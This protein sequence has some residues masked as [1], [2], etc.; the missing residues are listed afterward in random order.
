MKFGDTLKKIR[1]SR[2]ITQSSLTYGQLSHTSIS[3][4]E[5]NLTTPSYNNALYLI[6]QLG[7]T[8]GEFEYIRNNCQQSPK[9]ALIQ[10][11]TQ[12]SLLS[13]RTQLQ[14]FIGDCQTYL[15]RNFDQDIARL[16][17][18][19]TAL[20]EV[21]K[22]QYASARRLVEPVWYYLSELNL[23]TR[24]DL[25]LVNDILYFFDSKMA[26]Q[27]MLQ[28]LKVLQSKYP[29]LGELKLALV[30]NTSTITLAAQDFK[31]TQILLQFAG[32]LAQKLPRYDLWILAQ[33]RL[34]LCLQ[35]YNAAMVQCELLEEIGAHDLAQEA[36]YEIQRLA[37]VAPGVNS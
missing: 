32:K 21:K 26:V 19:V 10:A 29:Q 36:L 6:E 17:I 31:Q 14:Q 11:F 33:L 34:K 13:S 1:L 4:I 30:L 5:N 3:K 28:V 35:Q 23:W 37:R 25:Y 9:Q 7:L 8:V 15:K 16:V 22:H 24:L 27:V 18:V 20:Q 2:K 12:L